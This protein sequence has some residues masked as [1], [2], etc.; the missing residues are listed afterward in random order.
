MIQKLYTKINFTGLIRLQEILKHA[1]LGDKWLVRKLIP[2]GDNRPLFK[3]LK[4]YGETRVIIE[5]PSDRVLYYLRQ[6][7]DVKFFGD[8]MVSA[9]HHLMTRNSSKTVTLIFNNYY[10][11]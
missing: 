10:F 8:Y 1:E 7:F 6:A 4:T 9:F 5:C 3:S 11:I 2:H